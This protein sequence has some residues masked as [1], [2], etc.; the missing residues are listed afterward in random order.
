MNP[1]LTPQE[2]ATLVFG[3]A[4]VIVIML[5]HALHSFWKR[6]NAVSRKMKHPTMLVESQICSLEKAIEGVELD[7]ALKDKM[8]EAVSILPNLEA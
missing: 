1:G 6:G 7:Q 5:L 2:V 4:M 8:A 3:V